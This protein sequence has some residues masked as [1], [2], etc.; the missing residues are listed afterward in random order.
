LLNF[1]FFLKE[2]PIWEKKKKPHYDKKKKN[3]E[4]MNLLIDGGKLGVLLEKL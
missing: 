3:L 1:E 2:T 4:V